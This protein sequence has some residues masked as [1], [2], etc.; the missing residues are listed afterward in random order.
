MGDWSDY[1][2]NFPEANST[3]YLNG[4]F[5][6]AGAKLARE[7]EGTALNAD[8]EIRQMRAEAWK[9]EKQRS[10]I[11][12][13]DCPQCGWNELH[14]YYITGRYHL[15]ECQDCGIFGKG[16]TY[17]E[18]IKAASD[19]IG[20]GLDWREQPYPFQVKRLRDMDD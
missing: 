17:D 11:G 16:A 15:C 2:E 7:R 4:R 12:V 19:A 8:A 1:F 3:N 13:A 5:D 14:T 10:F 20:E 18:A 9:A 6:P